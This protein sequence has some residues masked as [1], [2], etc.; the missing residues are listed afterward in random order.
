M[1]TINDY[2]DEQLRYGIARCEARLSGILS[3]GLMRTE[4]RVRE[5][6]REYQTELDKRKQTELD[7]K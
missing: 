6:M 3:L 2:T 1:K 4:Y 5:A 7:F